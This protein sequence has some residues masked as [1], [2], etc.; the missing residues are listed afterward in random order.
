MC[1]QCNY[2]F[3]IKTLSK[4]NVA[5]NNTEV[6]FNNYLGSLSKILIV[7]NKHD[8]NRLVL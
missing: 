2:I 3:Q 1:S 7:W 5:V 8:F 4:L 6:H